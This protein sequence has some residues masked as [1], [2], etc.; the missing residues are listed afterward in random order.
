MRTV[1]DRLFLIERQLERLRIAPAAADF[2]G[3]PYAT[4]TVAAYNSA[5]TDAASA[6]FVCTGT[7]DQDTIM[8]AIAAAVGGNITLLDGEYLVSAPIAPP[9]DASSITIWGSGT[10]STYINPH[11]DITEAFN[12]FT[13]DTGI[14][15]LANF[16]IDNGYG[17]S[18]DTGEAH[19]VEFTGTAFNC[20]F[21]NMV[22][23]GWTNAVNIVTAERMHIRD[24]W[25]FSV[26]DDVV[27]GDVWTGCYIEGNNISSD[28][29]RGIVLTATV[30]G[31]I[32]RNYIHDCLGNAIEVGA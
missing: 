22:I 17:S 9:L 10:E 32:S 3:R 4:K 29:G 28:G 19:A 31:R 7:D 27:T 14:V 26:N 8:A 11:P 12:I 16:K 15:H 20:L 1:N 23:R 5:A 30:G 18:F 6:D 2:A 24:S 13:F 25:L 21:D